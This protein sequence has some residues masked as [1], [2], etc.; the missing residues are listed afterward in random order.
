VTYKTDWKKDDSGVIAWMNRIGRSLNA[1]LMP[2]DF[3]AIGDGVTDDTEALQA[4]IDAGGGWIPKPAAFYKTS[5]PLTITEDDTR[6]R[7]ANSLIRNASTGDVLTITGAMY[8]ILEGIWLQSV[9]AGEV[10]LRAIGCEH[11]RLERFSGYQHKGTALSLEGCRFT[12]VQQ[13]NFQ[14]EAD[15]S[16]VVEQACQGSLYQSCRFREASVGLD[17]IDSDNVT[18]QSCYFEA[19]TR[20]ERTG[21]RGHSTLAGRTRKV[22]RI[23][24]CYFENNNYFAVDVDRGYYTSV[25]G[26][27]AQGAS[28]NGV[29]ATDAFELG[30]G[31]RLDGLGGSN[32][33]KLSSS[34]GV[35]SIQEATG[36]YGTAAELRDPRFTQPVAEATN[37]ASDSYFAEGAHLT[38][39][40]TNAPAVSHDASIGFYG[41]ASAKSVFAA[42]AG[43]YAGAR[44]TLDNTAVS[45]EAGQLVRAL[46]AVKAD[47][48]GQLMA[49]RLAA[50]GTDAAIVSWLTDTDWQIVQLEAIADGSG[51]AQLL[52]QSPNPL[53]DALTL[54]IGAVA[55]SVDAEISLHQT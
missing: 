12:L 49:L 16:A 1:V 45:V 22:L 47:R 10:A 2:S 24:G 14:I 21:I 5:A 41:T 29:N 30:G 3:G 19:Q 44:M 53:A 54:W 40:G 17:L 50:T 55:I 38:A 43:G 37:Q 4:F 35:I 25:S 7:G 27:R 6:L 15:A 11:L 48:S 31:A 52:V 34:A 26:S 23:A 18:L 51:T 42:G 8:V 39:A 36:F 28:A 13:G 46:V 32:G 9:L 33:V 20:G